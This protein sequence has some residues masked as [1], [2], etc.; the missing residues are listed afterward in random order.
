MVS[1]KRAAKSYPK[2][3]GSQVLEHRCNLRDIF[4]SD[5]RARLRGTLLRVIF[6]LTHHV[7]GDSMFYTLLEQSL[8][9]VQDTT[10]I[11]EYYKIKHEHIKSCVKERDLKRSFRLPN[12]GICHMLTDFI[13]GHI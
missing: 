2:I 7:D 1:E 9:F 10:T 6:V 5:R 13:S 3:T 12:G 11:D 4:L 8:V